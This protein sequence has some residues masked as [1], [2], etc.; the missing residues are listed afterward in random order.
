[1]ISKFHLISQIEK[2]VIDDYEQQHSNIEAKIK[3]ISSEQNYSLSFNRIKEISLFEIYINYLSGDS[4]RFESLESQIICISKQTDDFFHII[5]DELNNCSAFLIN[6]DL[7][8]NSNDP[9]RKF[10]RQ[11]GKNICRINIELH[12]LRY[13][14]G[15]YIYLFFSFQ[16]FQLYKRFQVL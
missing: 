3:S 5:E 6:F 9:I 16:I 15:F 7:D 1:M 2:Y 13:C 11:K 4:N 8:E 12:N 10:S 14:F